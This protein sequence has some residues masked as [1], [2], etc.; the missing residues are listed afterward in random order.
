MAHTI[1]LECRVTDEETNKVTVKGLHLEADCSFET[2]LKTEAELE[3]MIHKWKMKRLKETAAIAN[4]TL[5]VP[6]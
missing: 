5:D 2:V 6:D 3:T 1:E 4:V